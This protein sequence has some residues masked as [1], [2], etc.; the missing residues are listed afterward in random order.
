MKRIDNKP[1]PLLDLAEDDKTNDVSPLR[2][3]N[4]LMW[5]LADEHTVLSRQINYLT[6]NI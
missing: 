6:F 3:V 4:I 5:E 2:I 1:N